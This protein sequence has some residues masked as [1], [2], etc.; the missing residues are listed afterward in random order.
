LIPNARAMFC[1]TIFPGI[2]RQLNAGGQLA[3][4]IGHEHNIRRF[5]GRVR[6]QAAHGDPDIRPRQDRRVVDAVANKGELA[7][8]FFEQFFHNP[9]FVLRQQLGI[10]LADAHLLGYR[11][12]MSLVITAQ[13]HEIHTQRLELR[14]RCGRFG[15]DGIGD[16]NIS[17][18]P[19]VY[20]NMDDGAQR[21]Y[22]RDCDAVLSHDPLISGN[23][24]L[25]LTDAVIPRPGIS[26]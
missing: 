15:L 4:L 7:F 23:H 8:A 10:D 11:F 24:R 21:N 25:P 14:G 9:D 1:Q 13:H 12:R 22:V 18:V 19:A 17:G 2:L 20:S 16:K 5:N 26:W 6:S 3:D